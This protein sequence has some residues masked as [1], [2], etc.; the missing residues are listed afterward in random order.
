[1]EWELHRSSTTLFGFVSS[2]MIGQDLPH[3]ARGD[4]HEVRAIPITRL[5]LC[6][7]PEI[8]LVD[9]GGRLERVSRPLTTYVRIR[10]ASQF[11]INQRHQTIESSLIA[12]RKLLEDQSDRPI[13]HTRYESSIGTGEMMVNGPGSHGAL[14]TL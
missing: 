8:S 6:D 1:V 4:A 7:Q 14:R 11:S 2:R 13:Q 12:G 10:Q 5:I 3:Q 9:Q